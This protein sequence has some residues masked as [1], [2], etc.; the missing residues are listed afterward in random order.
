M[1]NSIEVQS[2][3]SI[4]SK[5]LILCG[6]K[7]C[8][9]LS[10]NR[11]GV[12]VGAGLFDL[13]YESELASNPWRFCSMKKALS[14]LV[15]V[16]LNQWKYAYQ[17]PPEMIVPSYVFPRAQYEIYGDHLYTDVTAVELDFR[18]KPDISACPAY[19]SLLMVYALYK[20]MAKPVTES[21]AH[22]LKALKAYALQRDRALYAD[23]QGRPATPIQSN[24]FTEQRGRTI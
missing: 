18:F 15:N 7:P 17:L 24:P 8:T 4:I 16:P 19:F 2:K 9:S 22:A 12:T 6:E 13:V 20:D 3:I 11:Y 1:A 14:R 10:E 5:S 23:A 21:D